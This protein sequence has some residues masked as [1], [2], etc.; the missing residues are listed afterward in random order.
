MIPP[1]IH[2][3]RFLLPPDLIYLDG[4]SLGAATREAVDAVRSA[5]DAWVDHRIE[6]WT[7]GD[8]PWLFLPERL[9]DRVGALVGA[10]SGRV[11]AT[12][13]ITL[14]LHQLL[15]T[16][17]DGKGRILLDSTAF[18][19]DRF[20]VDSHV[21]LRGLDPARVVDRVAPGGDGLIDEA[22]IIDRLPG[23]SLAVLPSVVY[24][25]GQLLDM[26]RISAEGRACGTMVLWD[27][28]HSVG[29][30]PHRFD[31]DGVDAAYWCH[32][33]WCGAGPGAVAGLYLGPNMA[34]RSPG[35]AGWFGGRK[36]GLFDPDAEFD[37]AD[38]AAGLQTG[39]T[40]VFSLA[41]LSGALRPIEA[42][43]MAWIRA[44][45]LALT[46]H[47][48][49]RAETELVPL[50]MR[51]ATPRDRSRRGGHVALTH[52]EAGA[53]CRALRARRIVPDHRP[54]DRIRLA[55]SP[56][57]TEAAEIDQAVDALVE[58][59]RGADLRAG[60]SVGLVP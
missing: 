56:L 58:L 26:R 48:L 51:I 47:L 39:T 15:A 12:G 40:H 46:D 22:R 2:R 34:R 9:G 14:N 21:R 59:L 10:A 11:V 55:P 3:S 43:G 27:C 29:V 54:P 45:S 32:Y 38:G 17:W 23:A 52:P 42:A 36:E 25:T 20:A 60:D 37:P 4:N 57:H 28:A 19:T 41:A 49:A 35:I 8:H 31:A 24:T 5:V 50:G 1:S 30:V 7:E 16:L 18:P 6:G 33:K 13:S 44:R 53:L